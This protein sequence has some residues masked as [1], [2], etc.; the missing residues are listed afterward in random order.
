[1]ALEA[2]RDQL[3]AA[4]KSPSYSTT[5]Q[6]WMDAKR[7]EA[8]ANFSDL[9]KQPVV[10]IAGMG[11]TGLVG[12]ISGY[13]NGYKQIHS[14]EPRE[15]SR[16]QVFRLDDGFIQNLFKQLAGFDIHTLPSFHPLQGLIDLGILAKHGEGSSVFWTISIKDF[17]LILKALIDIAK[18]SAPEVI[19]TYP[20]TK[21]V[22][23][24]DGKVLCQDTQSGNHFELS[25]VDVLLGAD[26]PAS[27]VAASAGIKMKPTSDKHYHM[28]INYFLCDGKDGIKSLNTLNATKPLNERQLAQLG[29]TDKEPPTKR[30]FMT[31]K[32]VYLGA[33]ISEQMF[34]HLS[35]LQ[36][37]ISMAKHL[38]ERQI[39]ERQ[40]QAINESLLRATH[41]LHEQYE[42]IA[43][44][45]L[46]GE[47]HAQDLSALKYRSGTHFEVQLQA[48][49]KKAVNSRQNMPVML[50]G[51]ANATAH[52]QTGS[53]A[54]LGIESM[55]ELSNSLSQS[56]ALDPLA[57]SK[58]D[59]K[60]QIAA[61]LPTFDAL[62]VSKERELQ[63]K[64]DFFDDV[65]CNLIGSLSERFRALEL[66]KLIDQPAK[67]L[68][69]LYRARREMNEGPMDTAFR[70]QP[71]PRLSA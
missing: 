45:Y 59:T 60:S 27:R 16:E 19:H 14:I 8:I 68:Q 13:L 34:N 63:R 33:E 1:M 62:L 21:F 31:G 23:I 47:F 55:L 51:D 46:S 67:A 64:V 5:I 12:V 36:S 11:P 42:L 49:D 32:D 54:I 26:G 7:R 20:H 38:L 9:S 70:H 30:L 65:H 3:L 50:V 29:W 6:A 35:H 10:A 52:Y 61:Y 15:F 2:K 57:L 56:L 40:A 18:G 53:G 43:R 58:A 66:D 22:S 48:A 69:N 4:L 37:Q 41:E 24:D 71:R 25:Q 17:Q 28:A 44:V 39:P